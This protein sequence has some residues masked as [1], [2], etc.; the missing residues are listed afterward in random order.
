[1][2]Q[3][4]IPLG[5]FLGLELRAV[6]SAA[7]GSALIWLALAL[8]G[9]A[10]LQLDWAQA[11]LGGLIGT[12]LHWL[13]ELWHHVGHAR[14]ARKTGYPMTG[15][16][17]FWI[18]GRSLYPADEPELPAKTHIR[19]ALG[20]WPFSVMLAA[21]G[22]VLVLWLRTAPPLVFGLAVFFC[23]ENLFVFGLGAFLPLGFTDGSTLLK[24]WGK[25]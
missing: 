2:P 22:G 16:E 18:F 13:G 6:P 4:T 9:R 15:V 8:A 24:Y 25:Q 1:M 3:K 5:R 12:L 20:G 14:A 10:A 23:A 11:L 7:A 19:R 21:V 17:L